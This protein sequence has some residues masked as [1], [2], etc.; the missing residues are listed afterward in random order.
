[1]S[2]KTIFK[3][4]TEIMLR[5]TDAAGV[6]FFPRLLEIAHEAVEMLMIRIGFPI[7][8]MIDGE[9]HHLPIVHTEADFRLP[10]RLGD[11]L[12]VEVSLHKLGDHS[13]GFSCNFLDSDRNIKAI[14]RVDHVA[15]DPDTGTVTEVDQELK[16]ALIKLQG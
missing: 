7:S 6:L 13:L 12:T 5:H 4:E 8:N 1:M 9:L 15:I 2:P 14:T 16:T 3:L 10:C 11:K